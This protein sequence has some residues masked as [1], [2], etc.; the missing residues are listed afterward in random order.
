MTELVIAGLCILSILFVVSGL[1]AMSFGK[2][3]AR[4]DYQPPEV[5]P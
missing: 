1:L 5:K 4:D 3:A 2:A